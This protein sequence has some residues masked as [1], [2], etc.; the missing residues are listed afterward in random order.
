MPVRCC[1]LKNHTYTIII[2]LRKKESI[3]M[4]KRL[5][6]LALCCCLYPPI[7]GVVHATETE[8]AE[9][10]VLR[11][12]NSTTAEFKL[13][14]RPVITFSDGKLLVAS[15][16][17]SAEY[18]Q[19]D[20]TEFYFT[21]VS[22]GIDEKVTGSTMTFSYVDNAHVNIYGTKANSVL[23]YDANG[24]LLQRQKVTDGKASI[25]V[26]QYAPGVYVLNLTNEH[27]FK[28]IKK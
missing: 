27:S 20:V 23:L 9:F 11:M 22:T 1:L 6:S 26:S 17:A 24:R 4:R 14:T 8:Q 10:L 16:E 13:N 18:A 19:S 21:A 15:D 2:S 5:L 28:I 25:D 3:N 7:S 12:A